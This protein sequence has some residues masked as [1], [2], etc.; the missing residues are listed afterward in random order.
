MKTQTLSI[1]FVISLLVA[2]APSPKKMQEEIKQKEAVL[3]N[4]NGI[5]NPDKG[6]E[7]IALYADYFKKFPKDTLSAKYLFDAAGLK[8]TL[9]DYY[10]AI[11]LYDTIMARY[12][13]TQ[14]APQALFMKAFTYDNYLQRI[15]EARENYQRFIDSYP[16]HS[17]TNDAKKSMEFLGKSNEEILKMLEEAAQ[18]TQP[19]GN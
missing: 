16:N 6:N 5:L 11:S 13:R 18:T 14:V 9:K 7:M 17:L 15:N 12:P 2:C 1:F 10:G 8:I 19:K 3:F 4:E